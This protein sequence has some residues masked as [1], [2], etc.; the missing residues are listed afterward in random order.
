MGEG[1]PDDSH[2]TYPSIMQ[3]Q[4]GV[5]QTLPSR[6][7]SFT[8]ALKETQEKPFGTKHRPPPPARPAIQEAPASAHP[9]HTHTL[10]KHLFS[11]FPDSGLLALLPTL[12]DLTAASWMGRGSRRGSCYSPRWVL[13]PARHSAAPAQKHMP[14]APT[15]LPVGPDPAF[16]PELNQNPHL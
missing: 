8:G 12:P 5:L 14:Q 3:E 6:L 1:S 4:T 11:S 2:W 10:W 16:S 13:W 9:G 7:A 15:G